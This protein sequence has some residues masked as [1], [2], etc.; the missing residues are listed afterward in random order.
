M[1][2]P[3]RFDH[4]CNLCFFTLLLKFR[5]ILH[6]LQKKAVRLMI[7]GGKFNFA[8]HQHERNF[9]RGGLKP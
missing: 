1:Q 9:Y 3:V 7:L 2:E 6:K 4:L 5:V 8:I